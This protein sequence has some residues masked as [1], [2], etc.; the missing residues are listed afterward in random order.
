MF[1]IDITQEAEKDLEELDN[2]TAQIV[3]KK[4]WAIKQTPLHYLERLQGMTLW[5]LRIGDYRAIIQINTQEQKLIIIKVGHRRKIYK[6]L[7]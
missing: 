5:K 4:L 1:S 7:C 3:I 2:K 6:Q